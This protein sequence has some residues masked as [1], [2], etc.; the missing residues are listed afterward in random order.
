MGWGR[1]IP[2]MLI[3][4]QCNYFNI[5]QDEKHS[6]IGFCDSF[7]C[8]VPF[9]SQFFFSA[10][11]A[12]LVCSGLTHAQQGAGQ[13]P[14][15]RNQARPSGAQPPQT[16][17]ADAKR[18]ELEE[19]RR[20]R[21]EIQRHG[22]DFR[23]KEPAVRALPNSLTTPVSQP[24]ASSP[25]APSAPQLTSPSS[26]PSLPP[27]PSYF[28]SPVL[29]ASNPSTGNSA[30]SAPGISRGPALSQEERQQLRQQIRDERKRG[31][32]PTPSEVDR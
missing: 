9:R 15:G 27:L 30:S 7:R 4:Q 31:L 32:Y 12:L 6:K 13:A 22:P 19:R 25:S 21:Q 20:L 18:M 2:T 26:P 5:G 1:K 16:P 29:P 24:T 3:P 23:M 10:L 11:I 8:F 28:G 14:Q 17:P